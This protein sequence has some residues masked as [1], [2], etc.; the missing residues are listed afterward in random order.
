VTPLAPGES[1]TAVVKIK[2]IKG[3]LLLDAKGFYGASGRVY[4]DRRANDTLQAIV[5]VRR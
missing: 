3:P 2:N 4:D 1:Q 5:R